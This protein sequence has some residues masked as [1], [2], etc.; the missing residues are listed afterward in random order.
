M[1]KTLILCAI[2]MLSACSTEHARIGQPVCKQPIPVT[3]E[4]WG[5]PEEDFGDL[6]PLRNTMSTNQRRYEE[7]IAKLRGRI[8][9]H[10]Q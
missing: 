6:R 1:P 9:L 8:D 5:D 4:I 7:C 10:D 2:A 3:I